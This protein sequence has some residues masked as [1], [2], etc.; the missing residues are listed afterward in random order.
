MGQGQT[1]SPFERPPPTFC[2]PRRSQAGAGSPLTQVG[3][4]WLPCQVST[5]RAVPP[6]PPP[7]LAGSGRRLD[8]AP[9]W[10]QTTATRK[11]PRGQM[12]SPPCQ[13]P[14]PCQACW[15]WYPCV[16][17]GGNALVAAKPQSAS[18]RKALPCPHPRRCVQRGPQASSS[19]GVRER[20]DLGLS[21]GFL[22]FCSGLKNWA[23]RRLE[24]RCGGSF[25]AEAA[26]RLCTPD[27]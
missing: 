13:P 17:I 25:C 2:T 1:A 21:L 7:A 19:Q 6:P 3:D 15:D 23:L 20:G 11:P 5:P 14:H 8:P 9:L 24:G 16:R 26:R 10:G 18:C 12:T 22:L 27:V 4:P